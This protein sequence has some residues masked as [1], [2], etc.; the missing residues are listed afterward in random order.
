MRLVRSLTKI[1]FVSFS[2]SSLLACG[3]KSLP[4]LTEDQKKILSRTVHSAVTV[5]ASVPRTSPVTGL[6]TRSLA[7]SNRMQ[8]RL[9]SEWKGNRCL[10]QYPDL[11]DFS[12]TQMGMSIPQF[13]IHVTGDQCPM[14]L[15]LSFQA[16]MNEQ[17]VNAKFATIYSVRD[18]AFLQLNDIDTMTISGELGVTGSSGQ[19]FEIKENIQ[20]TI[21]S[22]KQGTVKV[23]LLGS[24]TAEASLRSE[25][26]QF[27]FFARLEF[28]EFITELKTVTHGSDSKFY[29]NGEEISSE[30]FSRYT[31]GL[32]AMS[33]GVSEPGRARHM[34]FNLTQ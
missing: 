31:E 4:Q 2:F 32:G 26:G 20:G 6:R 11:S 7:L 17:G 15:D 21:H 5:G 10:I 33:G 27:E 12:N 8:E 34:T 9:L 13:D 22:Q 3:G 29:L 24:G 16:S 30:S 1:L 28:P 25:S 23:T 19:T 14:L 18:P